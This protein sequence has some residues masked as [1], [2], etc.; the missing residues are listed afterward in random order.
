MARTQEQFRQAL[1]NHLPQ[2]EA[3]RAK[4]MAET[5]MYKLLFA[6]AYTY[7]LLD[8]RAFDLIDEMFPQTVLESLDEWELE[9]GL[10]APCYAGLELTTEERQ[11]I[12]L[13]KFASI[14]GQNADY[15]IKIADD[16][17]F[18][19]TITEYN[20]ARYTQDPY[21]TTQYGLTSHPYEWHVNV[22]GVETIYGKY[23]TDRYTTTQYSKLG[24][25]TSILECVINEL[26]PA[27]TQ[28]IFNY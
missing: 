2:G 6:L 15:Y 3:F 23:T 16:L 25:D 8:E 17:G 1:A 18:T 4:N 26:K 21:T 7:W 28:V 14:G 9:Y 24:I 22:S 5:V 20:G 10:P 19:I 27:H 13:T 11:K 12:L